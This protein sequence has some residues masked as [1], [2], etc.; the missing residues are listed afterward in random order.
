MGVWRTFLI[1]LCGLAAAVAAQPNA[2][3]A[4]EPT[5]TLALNVNAGELVR[6]PSP[7]AKVFVADPEIADF[8]VASNQSLL[9]FG[10]KPGRTTLYALSETDGVILSRRIA[11]QGSSSSSESMSQRAEASNDVF[12]VG[13]VCGRPGSN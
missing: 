10:R 13:R 12:A 7:A 5:E 8:Q 4:A 1:L 11:I 6:L 2:A 3:R 9:V